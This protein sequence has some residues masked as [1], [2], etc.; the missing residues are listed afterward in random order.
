MSE[1][2]L[3]NLWRERIS[4]DSKGKLSQ[5]ELELA[6]KCVESFSQYG[7]V[8]EGWPLDNAAAP[9]SPLLS[10]SNPLKKT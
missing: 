10:L 2:T 6:L 3:R 8:L 7:K 9:F 4:A 1:Q 5:E